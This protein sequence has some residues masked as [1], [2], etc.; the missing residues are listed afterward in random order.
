VVYI[1]HKYKG[2]LKG[3]LLLMYIDNKMCM[4]IFLNNKIKWMSG[5]VWYIL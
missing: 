2:V 1:D 3:N 4:G 5:D